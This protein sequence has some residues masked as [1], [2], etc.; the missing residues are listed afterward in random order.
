LERRWHEEE[1][2]QHGRR[3]EAEATGTGSADLLKRVAGTR[4]RVTL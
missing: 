2:E 4:N 3:D 1:R